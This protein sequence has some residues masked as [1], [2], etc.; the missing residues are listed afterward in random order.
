MK[1]KLKESTVIYNEKCL[2]KKKLDEDIKKTEE[3]STTFLRG[4]QE[5]YDR[6]IAEVSFVFPT[7]FIHFYAH[8]I[9]LY[10]FYNFEIKS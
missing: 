5:M 8:Y 1:T 6:E 4:C 9:V 10:T 7:G 3:K 2:V